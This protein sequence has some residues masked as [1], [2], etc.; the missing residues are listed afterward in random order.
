[1]GS[2]RHGWVVS[3]VGVAGG[4]ACLFICLGVHLASVSSWICV[5]RI[6]YSTNS[7]HH[8][9]TF[10]GLRPAF[11]YE[12]AATLGTGSTI[13]FSSSLTVLYLSNESKASA[14]CMVRSYTLPVYIWLDHSTT[15]CCHRGR[16]RQLGNLKIP[17]F[18]YLDPGQ[19]S[20]WRNVLLCF[21]KQRIILLF[22]EY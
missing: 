22:M 4:K 21:G 6:S 8:R 14:L 17:S 15:P 20:D 3:S 1:M 13:P 10:Q 18:D 11:R 9:D 7:P 16:C 12:C 2:L 19:D 5:Y